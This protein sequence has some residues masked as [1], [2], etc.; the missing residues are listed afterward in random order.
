ML[1]V[2]NPDLSFAGGNEKAAAQVKDIFKSYQGDY[3]FYIN[4]SSF[5]MHIYDRN[6][7][8][9]ASYKIT[10]GL[11]PD[12]KAKLYAG[13]NRTPEGVYQITEIL[14]QDADKN[15]VAYMTLRN[16]NSYYF[17]A[18]DG[19]YKFGKKDVDLG[20]NAYGPRFF[21]IS[22]PNKDDILRYN[23]ALKKN[24]IPK[25]KGKILSI[26]SGIAIHGNNDEPS[27][28]ELASSGCIR[29]RNNEIIELDKYVKL[30]LPVIISKD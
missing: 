15:S 11:N 16:M 9:V 18:R 27:I 6:L 13:D 14:S 1:S 4:K 3:L 7:N 25:Y 2:I 19:H 30:H 12:R 5:M 28:G 22:Y 24:M 20:Y 26:G 17:K 10:Y 21:R 8:I 23:D 29:M